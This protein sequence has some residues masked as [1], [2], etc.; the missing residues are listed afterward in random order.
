MKRVL[1]ALVLLSALFICT[2]PLSA[3]ATETVTQDGLSVTLTTDKDIYS[4]GELIKATLKIRNTNDYPIRNIRA[5]ILVPDGMAP[6]SGADINIYELSAGELYPQIVTLYETKTDLHSVPQTSDNSHIELWLVLLILSFLVAVY[7]VSFKKNNGANR[8]MSLFLCI[9]ILGFLTTDMSSVQAETKKITVTKQVIIGSKSVTITGI[10]NYEIEIKPTTFRYG[11]F[12]CRI[13]DAGN[14]CIIL[15]YIGS[16]TTVV[17]PDVINNLPLISLAD[18]AFDGKQ[19]IML[20]VTAGSVGEA[21]AQSHGMAYEMIGGT[22]PTVY[23]VIWKN[24]DGTILET[25]KDVASG[26]MPEFNGQT[27]VKPDDTQYTYI[28]KG[29]DPALSELTGNIRYTAQFDQTLRSYT[30]TW[31]MDDNNVLKIDENIP[32]GSMPEY[33]GDTPEKEAD[34]QNSYVFTSWTPEVSEV[35]GNIT[36]TAQFEAR[37]VLSS[38]DFEY[39]IVDEKVTIVGYTGNAVDVIVPDTIEGYPVTEIGLKAFLGCNTLTSI[40]LPESITDIGSS[41]FYGCTNLQTIEL[42]EGIKTL[43]SKVFYGCTGFTEIK[44]PDSITAMGHETFSG[45]TNLSKINIPLSWEMAYTYLGRSEIFKDC[46]S[47]TSIVVPEGMTKLPDYAFDG[48]KYLTSITLPSTLNVIGFDAFR[49]CTGL[50]GIEIPAGVVDVR[51]SAFSGCTNLQTIELPEGTKILGSKAFYKCTSFTEIKLPDSIT[52]M[53]NETFGSCT[54]LSKIN[55]PLLWELVYTDLGDGKIFKDCA[56]LTSIVV[57]EGITKLPDYAFD[58]ASFV[59]SL[60]LPSSLAKIGSYAFRNCRGIT[61]LYI[62]PNVTFI[63]TD[64]FKGANNIKIFCEYGSYALQ[65][66]MNNSIPYHFLSLI[67]YWLPNGTIYMGDDLHISGM[68]RSSDPIIDAE[69]KLYSPSGEVLRSGS[70][71]SNTTLISLGAYLDSCLSLSTLPLGTYSIEVSAATDEEQK[72]FVRSTFTVVKPPLRVSLTGASVPS[73]LYEIGTAFALK[74]T[75][76]S[77]YTITSITAGIY[78]QDGNPITLLATVFPNTTSYDL[79]NLASTAQISTLSDGK[80]TYQIRLISDGRTVTLKNSAFGMG[81]AGGDGIED[82]D[83]AQML[84]FSANWDNKLI[85]SPLTYHVEYLNSLNTWD[86]FA[87]ALISGKTIVSKEIGDIL[88][89]TEY[90]TYAVDLYKKQLA[91]AIEAQIDSGYTGNTDLKLY[92]TI[93]GWLSSFGSIEN[94]SLKKYL[95]N[96]EKNYGVIKDSVNLLSYDYTVSAA[97]YAGMLQLGEVVD[98]LKLVS[99]STSHLSDISSILELVFRDYEAGTKVIDAVADAMGETDNPNFNEAM[100]QVRMEYNANYIA[101]SI[102]L[103]TELRDQIG[104]TALSELLK[105]W[106]NNTYKIYS[107]ATDIIFKSTGLEGYTDDIMKFVTTT[108]AFNNAKRAYMNA[109][110]RVYGGDQSEEALRQLLICFNFTY[111]CADSLYYA[112]YDLSPIS[113]KAEVLEHINNDLRPISIWN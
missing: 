75:V 20:Q 81:T 95:Q 104:K 46:V 14:G 23:T 91:S 36:Y 7:I 93:F 89:D 110:D 51:G 90:N 54:N 13:N 103:L 27:P 84:K 109:F 62:S 55:I 53:S 26:S 94:D 22:A 49:N 65:Y 8:W 98:G 74:G 41:A 86:A 69:V 66:A 28:F 45:C 101:V 68:I 106:G 48:A 67:N 77:N 61:K 111:S 96:L 112:L 25:D 64:A 88:L 108:E 87:I 60:T 37:P 82:E 35:T 3:C 85:F 44:L 50:T 40:K 63:G 21:Y 9:I 78:S 105:A 79:S 43:G 47:L 92:N 57:P 52:T 58:G 10:V 39:S 1:E 29:W 34:A 97:T 72:T 113:K 15:T 76:R 80:Y 6:I 19:G 56:A 16:A 18:D 24:Y 32:Y 102:K 33:I 2:F 38:F 83:L 31:V 42:S 11:D 4:S 73:G 12:L 100:K 17:V 30:I 71:N 70:V 99:S 107:L 59:S 5:K